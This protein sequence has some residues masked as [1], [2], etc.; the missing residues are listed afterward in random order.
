M[1]PPQKRSNLSR[2]FSKT[3]E[4]IVRLAPPAVEDGEFISGSNVGSSRQRSVEP[5]IGLSYRTS[6]TSGG[7]VAA[8]CWVCIGCD[9]GGVV[10]FCGILTVVA[11]AG[12]IV[13]TD[14]TMESESVLSSCLSLL[15]HATRKIYFILLKRDLKAELCVFSNKDLRIYNFHNVF[16]NSHYK[17][18]YYLF[19]VKIVFQK[20]HCLFTKATSYN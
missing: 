14:C 10:G 3:S 17:S 2:A 19:C 5:G 8:I 11:G 4:A 1:L 6:G 12:I 13:A 15:F 9:G 20:T 7:C 18:F 16:Y